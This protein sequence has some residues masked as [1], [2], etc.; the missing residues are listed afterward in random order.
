[1]TEFFTESPT[2]HATFLYH[3][4][5]FPLREKFIEILK[6]TLITLHCRD[7]KCTKRLIKLSLF[8]HPTF[9][10]FMGEKLVRLRGERYKTIALN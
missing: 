4:C 9:Q 7:I 3:L 8:G 10:K 1:M 2:S 5:G 6:A